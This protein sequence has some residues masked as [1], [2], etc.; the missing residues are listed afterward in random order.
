M[1]VRHPPVTRLCSICFYSIAF[2]WLK[3][4]FSRRGYTSADSFWA[5][6][7][8]FAE[9]GAGF[10]GFYLFGGIFVVVVVFAVLFHCITHQEHIFEHWN[11]TCTHFFFF[12][13]KFSYKHLLPCSFLGSDWRIIGGL[14]IFLQ[15]NQFWQR[16][17]VYFIMLTRNKNK[18]N[19]DKIKKCS[20][21]NENTLV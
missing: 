21:G 3:T 20:A 5:P 14:I 1:Q 2:Q 8:G 15:A 9:G 7:R 10:F 13:E 12:S 16:C 6:R 18:N 4:L 11:M 19:N 17:K